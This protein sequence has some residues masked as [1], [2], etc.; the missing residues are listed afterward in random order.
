MAQHNLLYAAFVG[1]TVEDMA[2]SV[3]MDAT[4]NATIVVAVLVEGECRYLVT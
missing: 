4:R 2:I 3:I 1:L